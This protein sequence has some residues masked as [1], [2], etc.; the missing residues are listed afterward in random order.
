MANVAD[1]ADESLKKK[2]GSGSSSGGGNIHGNGV[3]SVPK[4][5]G[6]KE[7]DENDGDVQNKWEFSIVTAIRTLRVAVMSSAQRR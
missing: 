2:T 7:D 5:S 3:G 1:N 6:L 4:V